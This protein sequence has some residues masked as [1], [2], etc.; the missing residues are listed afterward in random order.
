MYDLY[1]KYDMYDLYD[2][3]AH[4]A[5]WEPYIQHGL[6]RT[7]HDLPCLVAHSSWAGPELLLYRYLVLLLRGAIV[8]RTKYC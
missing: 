8:N 5:G 2:L 1:D 3:L 4:A 7:S 6:A